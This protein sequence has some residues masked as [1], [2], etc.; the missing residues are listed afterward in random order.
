MGEECAKP[1]SAR[2]KTLCY[3]SAAGEM[4]SILTALMPPGMVL[5]LLQK[6]LPKCNFS[7]DMPYSTF[8]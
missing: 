5:I 3:S 6:R 8:L 4:N 1:L 2:F 7:L